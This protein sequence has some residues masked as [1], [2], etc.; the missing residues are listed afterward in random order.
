VGD[1][2]GAT[3]VNDV[4]LIFVVIAVCVVAIGAVMI[5]MVGDE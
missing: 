1:D 2:Q 4:D 5:V 3:A